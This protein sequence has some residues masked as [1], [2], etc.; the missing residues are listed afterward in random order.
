VLRVPSVSL[1]PCPFIDTFSCPLFS[2]PFPFMSGW[3]LRNRLVPPLSRPSPFLSTTPPSDLN[4]SPFY[5]PAMES[6]DTP[7]IPSSPDDRMT[8][9]ELAL[10]A[11]TAQL[12]RLE[13]R[14]PDPVPP[15]L[16]PPS[17][18]LEAPEIRV[19]NRRYSQVLAVESY[20]LRDRTPTLLPDQVNDLTRAANQIRPRLEGCF[21]TG[22]PP[23]AVLPFLWQLV[24]V[25]DQSH[26]SEA[27]VL[28]V[29]E[30]FLRSP[31][32][33]SFRAQHL[34]TWPE[35]VHWLIV[36]FA[37]EPQLDAA[38]RR[39][40]TT[41][42]FATES[43]RQYGLRLQLEAAALGSL[44]DAPEVKSLFSQGL[45][46][47][48]RS[49]FAAH[50]PAGELE[51]SVPLSVLVSRATLLENGFAP[52]RPPPRS[53]S[54]RTPVFSIPAEYQGLEEPDDPDI[55]K[56]LALS[57]RS[58]RTA[59]D[60][61]TCYVCFRQGH[62]WIDCEWLRHVPTEEKEEAL[63]RRRAHFDRA[64]PSSPVNRFVSSYPAAAGQSQ[65]GSESRYAPPSSPKNVAAPPRQ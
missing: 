44:L 53:Y 18:Q 2:F 26:M 4:L 55:S 47:P 59:T 6:A 58:I 57:S 15:L 56:V 64:R 37:A 35:A 20:R 49:L 41:S 34:N 43:V 52:S 48:V 25:A 22:D 17:P 11:I 19:R 62:G 36:T 38:V 32:K 51:D 14:D 13:P 42:Q 12:A 1:N 8:Q 63:L 39:L 33:E 24:R 54:S 3:N 29:V 7:V 31:V 28:W 21:F 60:K 50:Q 40:Q 9:I 10:N 30:D 23:L 5:C 46:E 27:T 45:R 61:W 16:I 65:S